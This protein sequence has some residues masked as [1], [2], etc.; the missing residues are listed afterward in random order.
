MTAPV[1]PPLRIAVLGSGKGSNYAAIA[2]A[3]AEDRLA[4]RVVA[5]V[6]DVETAGILDLAAAHG[7]PAIRLAPGRFKHKLE[8]EHERELA[9]TLKDL[10]A[11]LVVLAGFMRLLKEPMVGAFPRRIINIHPSLLPKYPG[12]EAWRQALAAGDTET[13]CSVHYVD[14]GMDT[15]EVIAQEVV[16]I[17]AKDTPETLHARIQAAEH[18]LYPRVIA[19]LAR[20]RSVSG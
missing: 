10:E 6:S 13:G 8:P 2:T 1:Q 4:A 16:P 20:L 18:A 12:L 14:L 9:S 5:V 3:I 15:G 17:L 11:D 7:A 19:D